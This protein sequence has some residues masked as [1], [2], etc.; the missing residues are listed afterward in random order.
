MEG[1][2]GEMERIVSN[3]ALDDG[4]KEYPLAQDIF[5]EAPANLKW[6][7]LYVSNYIGLGQYLNPE[8]FSVLPVKDPAFSI[9]S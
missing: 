1:C 6:E 8:C 5:K 4:K 7:R 2:R 3:P 9:N